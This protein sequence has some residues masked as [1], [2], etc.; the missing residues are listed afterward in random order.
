MV[1]IGM[2]RYINNAL[3]NDQRSAKTTQTSLTVLSLAI[4][5]PYESIHTF[6]SSHEKSLRR[7]IRFEGSTPCYT[8][9][10]KSLVILWSA[11]TQNIYFTSS[12][13]R[14]YEGEMPK[15]NDR[16]R[17]AP[18]RELLGSSGHAARGNRSTI[19]SLPLALQLDSCLNT[20]I[21][22]TQTVSLAEVQW[23]LQH[24]NVIHVPILETARS[25]NVWSMALWTA[26]SASRTT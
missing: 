1:Y 4:G 17:W 16:P 10:E 14:F 20:N 26:S 6:V 11:W 3:Q 9:G 2:A 5:T 22:Q 7:D 24:G 19:F 12:H 23:Q 21:S 18:R 15:F 13:T 8:D 25:L